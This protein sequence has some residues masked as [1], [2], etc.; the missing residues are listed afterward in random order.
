MLPN[1]VT[2]TLNQLNDPNFFPAASSATETIKQVSRSVGQYSTLHR[3]RVARFAWF[4]A[5]ISNIWRARASNLA[6]WRWIF[7]LHRQFFFK[8]RIFLLISKF[9][10]ID[11]KSL[12][13]GGIVLSA[14]QCALK[15]TWH[16]CILITAHKSNI[17]H[18]LITFQE[19]MTSSVAPPSSNS[20]M[21]GTSM[22]PSSTITTTALPTSMPAT[23]AV[24]PPAQ[25][26]LGTKP[27]LP[28]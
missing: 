24:L 16:P 27:I 21:V 9:N 18:H 8:I 4:T 6:N 7:W 11:Y 26:S 22:P 3:F 5:K 17:V 19:L 1:S 15:F 23:P 20:S 12:N 10:R 28:H 14:W 25:V 2:N 13:F